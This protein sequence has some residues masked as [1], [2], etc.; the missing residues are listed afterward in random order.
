MTNERVGKTQNKQFVI[1]GWNFINCI[2]ER[3]ITLVEDKN[4]SQ[5]TDGQISL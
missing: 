2:N 4:N 3:I 5:N 1:G